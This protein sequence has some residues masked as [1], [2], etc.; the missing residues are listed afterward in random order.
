MEEETVYYFYQ[1]SQTSHE[2][3]PLFSSVLL[4]P[5]N[6]FE[7]SVSSNVYGLL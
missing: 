4:Q 3:R 6:H 7:R 2:N 5:I 1:K